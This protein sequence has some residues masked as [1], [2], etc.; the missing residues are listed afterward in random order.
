MRT[1]QLLLAALATL[2]PAA[3]GAGT[4]SP[5]LRIPQPPPASGFAMQTAEL[6]AAALL[7]RPLDDA[8]ITKLANAGATPV[9]LAS[10]KPAAVG[11]VV[12]LRIA[13]D[14]LDTVAAL[15]EVTRLDP[16]ASPFDERPLNVT[17]GL[18]GAPRLWSAP[19]A[20]PG[21]D[22]EGVTIGEVESAWDIYHPDLFRPDAGGYDFVDADGDGKAGPG[23]KVDLDGDGTAES[24]LALFDTNEGNV[25]SMEIGSQ[26]GYQPDID[27]LY[28]DTDGN[29]QRD[30]GAWNG[31][32]DETPAL[33]EPIFAADDLNGD[34]FIT[35][36]ERLIRLGSS[37]VKAVIAASGKAYRR[38]EN[39]SSYQ[40]QK[41]GDDAA[42]Y[43]GTGAI[44]IA[45]SGWPGLRRYTGVAPGA[46]LVLVSNR[47]RTAALA[48]LIEENVDLLFFE[49]ASKINFHDGST[50][51]EEAI[52]AAARGGLPILTPTGNLANDSKTIRVA[53]LRAG[54]TT[55]VGLT[56][57]KAGMARASKANVS[58]TWRGAPD[59]ASVTLV[60][61]TG[62]RLEIP[63]ETT[64]DL[65]LGGLQID[66]IRD[67][68][69][70]GTAQI[71]LLTTA[72][73]GGKIPEA[74]WTFELSSPTGLEEIRAVVADDVSGWDAGVHFLDHVDDA[75]SVITPATADEI[76]AVSAYI[77]RNDQGRD[78]KPGELARYACHG[79]RIDG[80]R[81]VDLVAPDDPYVCTSDS[82]VGQYYVSFGGTSGAVPH[83][84]GA[85]ALLLQAR[86]DLDHAGVEQALTAAARADASTGTV[87]NDEAGF[88][89]LDIAKAVLGERPTPN[90]PPTV[91]LELDGTAVTGQPATVHAIVDDPDGNEAEAVVEFDVGWDG[92]YEI[93]RTS[94]RET[95]FTVPDARLPIVARVTDASGAQTRAL[96]DVEGL[97]PCTG[98]ACDDDG[99]VGKHHDEGGGCATGGG[100]ALPWLAALLASPLAL[101]RRRTVP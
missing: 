70:R 28:V 56:T 58:F 5:L 26:P 24:T 49:T 2:A 76:I 85:A 54:E 89:K 91:R 63:L 100:T 31:F 71:L 18:V 13:A 9:R 44:G 34:G 57:K 77:G 33:G 59:D 30:V 93:T 92:L 97:P 15:P 80:A 98:P 51:E 37:K 90:A 35:P 60:S 75:A 64:S 84:A 82:Y 48:Q 4:V 52:S 101:R 87:P 53:P 61:A 16:A 39:L 88:G 22:G 32:T 8:L 12:S 41:E 62:E 43:H 29:G 3:A 79:T 6:E 96:L 99:P 21:L 83:A 95:T 68:S 10:G 27:W 20:L 69:P 42:L 45:V 7:T 38:G 19:A 23:D 94:T 81:V 11:N 74:D 50:P 67:L 47:D 25:Y 40:P 86:P 17:T 36:G 66:V 65:L 72:A 55:T 1:N 78:G 14:R 46:E 73:G